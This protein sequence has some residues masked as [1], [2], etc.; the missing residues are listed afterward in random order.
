[1]ELVISPL[2]KGFVVNVVRKQLCV[3]NRARDAAFKNDTYRKN[4]KKRK[5]SPV[6]THTLAR[7]PPLI[8][9]HLHR[10]GALMVS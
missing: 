4:R 2:K 10:P 5:Q 6:D 8:P 9:R 1:M 7:P 3:L